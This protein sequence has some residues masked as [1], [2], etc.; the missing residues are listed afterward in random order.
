[1]RGLKGAEYICDELIL[2][3][4][5]T[6][7]NPQQAIAVRFVANETGQDHLM[8]VEFPGLD[9]DPLKHPAIDE[10]NIKLLNGKL[11]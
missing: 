9:C 6:Y 3:I 11:F 1:M 7:N 2:P 5:R 4:I 8:M 10:L